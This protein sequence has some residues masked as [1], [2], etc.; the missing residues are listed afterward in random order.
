MLTVLGLLVLA[1]GCQQ[2]T[3]KESKTE[4]YNKWSGSR[5]KVLHSLAR[6]H[7]MGGHIDKA[8]TKAEEGLS[9][10]PTNKDLQYL[11]ARIYIEKG[12]YSRSIGLLQMLIEGETKDAQTQRS[13]IIAEA[14]YLLGVAQEKS[15]LLE[16]ALASY[17]QSVE[18][19]RSTSAPVLA[20]AEVLISKGQIDKA[21]D[22]LTCQMTRYT[23]EPAT[24]ELSG[25]LAMMQKQYHQA[26]KQWQLACD[27]DPKNMRYPEMLASAQYAAGEYKQ[28]GETLSKLTRRRD[29]K[30]SAWVYSLLGDCLMAYHRY[31]PAEKAYDK[32]CI[33]RPE[34]PNCWARLAKAALAQ[35][36]MTKAI[37]SA[38]KARD[39]DADN[40]D[41]SMLLGYAMIRIDKPKI[42]AEIL[43]DAAKTHPKDEL[44][45]CL[46]GRA[47][48]RMGR[49]D[50]SRRC[51]DAAKRIQPDS[52][53]LEGLLAIAK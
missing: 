2:P 17:S 32:A 15:G 49:A 5:A 43:V 50:L 52:Q 31:E 13:S 39:L 48:S 30:G 40:L 21:Q 29:Y 3:L 44:V 27:L 23:P 14:Y 7:L 53:L 34:D 12:F 1:T 42:A 25:R 26:A 28:A 46:L 51:Y 47:Y 16:E 11:L 37:R 4:A 41:A 6:D 45:L 9:L 8:C 35:N 38:H 24:A 20:A 19:D 22:F 18:L 36:R 10:D 33:L